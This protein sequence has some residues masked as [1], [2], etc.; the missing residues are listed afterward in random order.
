MATA[1]PKRSTRDAATAPQSALRLLQTREEYRA[2]RANIFQTK[3]GLEWYMKLHR[4]ALA[5]AGATLIISQRQ[6]IDPAR[7]DEFVIKAGREL[8]ARGRAA[9]TANEG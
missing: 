1:N 7:F 4:E 8:S 6:L 9:S 5:A 2:A 3:G